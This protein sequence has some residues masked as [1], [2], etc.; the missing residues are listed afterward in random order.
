MKLK[1]VHF[2]MHRGTGRVVDLHHAVQFKTDLP[3]G[4]SITSIMKKLSNPLPLAF[5]WHFISFSK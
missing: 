1:R 4:I 3:I 5:S 2:C